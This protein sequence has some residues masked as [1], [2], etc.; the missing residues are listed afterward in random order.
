MMTGHDFAAWVSK[1]MVQYA[2]ARDAEFHESLCGFAA[3]LGVELSD[4]DVADWFVLD[5]ET[6]QGE[7]ETFRADQ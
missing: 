1:L 2:N 4:D 6:K 3:E 5:L 7:Y